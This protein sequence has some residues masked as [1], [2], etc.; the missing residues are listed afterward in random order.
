MELLLAPQNWPFAT[1]LGLSAL[2]ALLQV[3]ML[4][5][6]GA[7][8]LLEMEADV[9]L[10]ADLDGAGGLDGLLDWLHVGRLPISLLL[11]LGGLSFGLPGLFIQS[12]AKTQT[13]GYWPT[14]PVSLLAAVSA[15]PLLRIGGLLLRRFLPRDE[16]EAVSS[17]SFIGSEAIITIGVSKRG[18]PAEARLYDRWGKAHYVLVEPERPE[19][20]FSA[21]SAVLLISQHEHIFRAID[22]SAT[23]MALEQIEAAPPLPVPKREAEP[24]QLEQ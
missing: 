7:I 4:A 11:M 17:E 6:G 2:L 20:E 21:G 5:L 19:D 9:D 24:R 23:R 22:N 1:A 18:R 16:T 15:V 14:G 12:V 10:D 8:D 13:G 3:L